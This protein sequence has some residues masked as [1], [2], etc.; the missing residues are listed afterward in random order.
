MTSL[1]DK[2]IARLE[3]EL[4]QLKRG[5]ETAKQKVNVLVVGSGGREHTIAWKLSQSKLAGVIYF[6]PGNG[7]TSAEKDSTIINVPTLKPVDIDGIVKFAKEN[8]IGLVVVGP[9]VPLV[10]GCG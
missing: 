6:G 4:A 2:K 7:G 5:R 9:E 10:N 8:S 1:L 3:A